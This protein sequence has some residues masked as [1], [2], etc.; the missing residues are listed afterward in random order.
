MALCQALG[1]Q[2]TLYKYKLCVLC[3]KSRLTL[4]DLMITRLLCPWDSPGKNTGVGL[5]EWVYW[6]GSP[7]PPPGVFLDL[8]IEPTCLPSPVLAGGFSTTSATWDL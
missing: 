2:Q 1:T 3:A 4:C 7:C 5:L 6:S 8:G